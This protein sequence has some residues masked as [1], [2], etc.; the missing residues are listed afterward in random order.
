MAELESTLKSLVRQVCD[1]LI[2]SDVPLWRA[3]GVTV[4]TVGEPEKGGQYAGARR[5]DFAAGLRNNARAI[6]R[7]DS[8]ERLLIDLSRHPKVNELIDRSCLGH[9]KRRMSLSEL[10]W[11]VVGEPFC[12]AYLETAGGPI[13]AED[14][15][16]ETFRLLEDAMH[17]DT[18][19]E[20]VLSPLSNMLIEAESIDLGTGLRMR[21]LTP[22]DL[23]EW[24]SMQAVYVGP[25]TPN[26]YLGLQCAIEETRPIRPWAP[27][28]QPPM[29]GPAAG[30]VA[31]LR[32]VTGRKVFC[33]FS[34]LRVSRVIRSTPLTVV[35]ETPHCTDT[36]AIIRDADVPNLIGLWR[37]VMES[38][39][40]KVL[41][42]AIDRWSAAF[43]QQQAEDRLILGM[44]ALRCLFSVDIQSRGWPEVVSRI[45]RSIGPGGDA[46]DRVQAVL[47]RALKQCQASPESPLNA[48]ADMNALSSEV[49]SYSR[50]AILGMAACDAYGQS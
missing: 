20:T 26:F 43:L 28:P 33:G 5:A 39:K 11:V 3:T 40:A 50:Q 8:V 35:W 34:E 17:A 37:Q 42:Y 23:E 46:P 22:R 19:M 15:F 31:F 14:R 1:I 4:R 10:S 25:F 47:A 44:A 7:I 18:V 49:L 27:I 21:R 48:T 41:S 36:P 13:W 2:R 29:L 12:Q 38:S 45:A 16:Q 32:V 30:V 9:P 24:L 6:T